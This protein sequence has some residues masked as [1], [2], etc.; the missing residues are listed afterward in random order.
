MP[1]SVSTSTA[2]LNKTTRLKKEQF[3]Q[4]DILVSEQ[5]IGDVKSVAQI[6]LVLNVIFRIFLLNI[7]ND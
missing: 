3:F 1:T 5:L 6:K 2:D 7:I 4:I